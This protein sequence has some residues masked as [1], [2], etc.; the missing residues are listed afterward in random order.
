MLGAITAL[1]IG[2]VLAAAVVTKHFTG[3]SNKLIARALNISEGTVKV[4]VEH[5][6]RKLEFR[7]QAEAAVWATELDYGNSRAVVG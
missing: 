4:H 2:V 1:A 7:S 6:L 5:L 3:M